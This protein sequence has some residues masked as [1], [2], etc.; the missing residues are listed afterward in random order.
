MAHTEYEIKVL[1]INA[2]Q[3]R[4]HLSELGFTEQPVLAF[5]RRVYEFAGNPNAW[6]RLRTDGAKTTLT[7]KEYKHDAIDGVEEIE[8]VVDNFDLTHALLEKLG[9]SAK[10]YQENRRTLFVKDGDPIEISIDEWPLIPA[11]MEIEGPSQQSVEDYLGM[12]GLSEST[13]T[14]APTSEVY[15]KYNLNIND[16]PELNFSA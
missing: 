9:Y 3:V 16:Y 4:N 7:Y 8:V 6:I 15:N 1:D 2:G 14:S 12:L 5:R 13:T 11:Y 10:N